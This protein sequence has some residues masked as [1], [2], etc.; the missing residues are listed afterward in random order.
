MF[1]HFG[2]RRWHSITPFF[3]CRFYCHNSIS[4][5]QQIVLIVAC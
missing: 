2:H 5:D 3:A 4:L 1:P